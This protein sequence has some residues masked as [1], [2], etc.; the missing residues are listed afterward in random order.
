[1]DQDPLLE[2]LRVNAALKEVGDVM[3]SGFRPGITDMYMFR[4]WIRTK[5][6]RVPK[7]TTITITGLGAGLVDV[8]VEENHEAGSV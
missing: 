3:P 5:K 6:Y 8:A 1:M 2:L 7:G 4:D